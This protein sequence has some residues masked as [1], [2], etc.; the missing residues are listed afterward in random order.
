MT[1]RF[2]KCRHCGNVIHKLVDSK[3]PVVCCGTEMEELTPNTEE[4]SF[5]KHL[6]HITRLDDGILK[7]RVGSDPHPMLLEH[8][9]KFIY[10]ECKNGGMFEKL[11][12]RL[13]AEATFDICSCEPVA[14]YE[15]CNIHGLWKTELK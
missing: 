4:A 9:I 13:K 1:T 7:V 11:R 3:I 6:P 8:H 10:V 14:V 5:E 12:G 2:Y 15:Y